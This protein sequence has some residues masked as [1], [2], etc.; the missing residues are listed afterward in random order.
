L[1]KEAATAANAPRRRLVLAAIMGT[2]FMIAIEATIVATAMPSIVPALGHFE[3]YS[4][5][6][7]IYLLTQAVT[8]PIYGKLA[9]LYGRGRVLA[10]GIVVFLL[11][12]LFC[13]FAGSMLELIVHRGIQGLG[14]GALF[15][16][17]ITIVGD[18]YPGRERAQVQGYMSSVWGVS[19]VIGPGLGALIVE[20]A[21]WPLVFW[22]NLPLG[23]VALAM[24]ARFY[25]D[26]PRTEP[27]A[28]DFAGA[29]L[30]M[31]AIGAVMVALVESA[32]WGAP[33]LLAL[34]A[35]AAAAA[36][37]FVVQE[38]RAPDPIVPFDL[39]RDRVVVTATLGMAALGA[40]LI[41][42]I[43]YLPSHMQGAMGANPGAVAAAMVGFSVAWA[44]FSGTAG[45]L[46]IRFTTAS[47]VG[48]GGAILV[49]GLVALY[50]IPIDASPWWVIAAAFFVGGGL[51][52][53]HSPLIVAVQ[54]TVAPERRGTATAIIHFSRMFGQTVGAALFGA[55]VNAAIAARVAP[56][57][58]V[59]V[60]ALL[61]PARR[62]ALAPQALVQLSHALDGALRYVYAVAAAFA[63]AVVALATALP[64]GLKPGGTR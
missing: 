31:V 23:I 14:A 57:A 12:S 45:R 61:D 32:T 5:V 22:I 11:G 25:R 21:R 52:F 29:F 59:E 56:A 15:P 64:K 49:A 1:S 9:D 58:G 62:A 24:L 54:T 55:I 30:L 20:H 33:A 60:E 2:I 50:L 46:T 7:S 26:R 13:G 43:A 48:A 10:F 36:V 38:R 39:W 16:V 44:G 42:V 34:L 53:G 19:A 6:F 51:G 35:L 40:L 8:T 28:I 18:L 3:L 17:A 41:A 4:W 63:L 27:V 47:V 37:G